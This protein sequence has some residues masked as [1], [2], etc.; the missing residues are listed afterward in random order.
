MLTGKGG[1][2]GEF[3]VIVCYVGMFIDIGVFSVWLLEL[4]GNRQLC[5]ALPVSGQNK[6]IVMK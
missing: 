1:G 3:Q 2:G 4:R 6:R 5:Q